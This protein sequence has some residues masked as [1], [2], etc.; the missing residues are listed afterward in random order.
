[1]VKNYIPPE[2]REVI[3]PSCGGSFKAAP[4]AR[5]RRIQCP[6]CREVVVIENRAE[7]ET[8]ARS[9]ADPARLDALEARVAALEAALEGRAGAGD[10]EQPGKLEW[11]SAAQDRG[12]DYSAGQEKVLVDNLRAVRGQQ[13]TIRSC[14]ENDAD[15]A[16]A[17]WFRK[18]FELAGWT[19]AGPE[20]IPRSAS[21]HVLTLAVPE[22]PVARDAA[23]TYLALKAAGFR[24]EPVLDPALAS[25]TEAAQLSLTIPVEPAA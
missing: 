9:A 6:H 8:A 17:E 4:T 19:V 14:M 22:L 25:G 23:K 12:P 10:A 2:S 20:R 13:I 1:M 24:T 16:H 3:C 7:P 5:T 18:V 15:R 21:V 11:F